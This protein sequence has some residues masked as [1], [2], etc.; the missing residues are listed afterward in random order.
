MSQSMGLT[1]HVRHA[2][3]ARVGSAKTALFATFTLDI[4]RVVFATLVNDF[5]L[6]DRCGIYRSSIG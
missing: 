2:A 1:L 6:Y 4:R 5:E 3:V